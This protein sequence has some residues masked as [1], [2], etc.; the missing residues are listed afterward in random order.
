MNFYE[1][2]AEVL[3]KKNNINLVVGDIYDYQQLWLSWYKGSVSDFHFYKE[4]VAG[5]EVQKEREK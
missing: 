1:N 4:V 2:V 5:K 3:R